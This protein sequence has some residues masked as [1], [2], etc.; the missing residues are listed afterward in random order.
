MLLGALLVG[1]AIALRRWLARGPGAHRAGYTAERIS[2][3]DRDLL[4]LAAN[5]SVAWHGRVYEQQAPATSAPPSF[6]GGRSGG[7][8]AAGDY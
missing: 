2:A 8:G 7:G 6:D 3:G 4:Q 1:G 5:T